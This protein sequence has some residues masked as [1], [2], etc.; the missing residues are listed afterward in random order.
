MRASCIGVIMLAIGC[1]GPANADD[2]GPKLATMIQQSQKA[3]FEKHDLKEYLSIWSDDVK[4]IQGRSEK[5][6]KYDTVLTRAQ[7][8]ATRK[9]RFAVPPPK[10]LTMEFQNVKTE[11]KGDEAAVRY[12][13]TIRM[14]AM[15]MTEDEIFRLRR[16]DGKWKVYENR[17]WPIEYRG[18]DFIETYEEGTWKALD[19]QASR[20]ASAGD[21]GGEMAPLMKGLR[22]ADAH[23][24]AKK[25]TE[26]EGKFTPPW[27]ARGEAAMAIGDVADAKASFRKALEIDPKAN[28]SDYARLAAKE[29]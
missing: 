3:G 4:M 14:P 17:S 9:L 18:S 10:D 12:R 21:L 6:D 27:L 26:K 25:W 22:Y 23:A 1:S 29:K 15:S 5:S 20:A 13:A 24:V 11:V 19:E 8:E 2:E 16:R 28:L 7:I